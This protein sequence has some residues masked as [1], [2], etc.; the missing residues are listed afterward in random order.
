MMRQVRDGDALTKTAQQAKKAATSQVVAT[1]PSSAGGAGGGQV[2]KHTRG[3][4]PDYIL[5]RKEQQ[6][7]LQVR[8]EQEKARRAL[9]PD[10]FRLVSQEE[11]VEAEQASE[12]L[13]ARERTWGAGWVG[14]PRSR[15]V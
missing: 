8:E 6:R 3:Q 13:R 11:R 5:H 1:R 12:A 4:V 9:V 15:W 14:V 10:G 7:L 2:V